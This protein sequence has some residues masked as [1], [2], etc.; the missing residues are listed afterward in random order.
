MPAKAVNG[1][2]AYASD[3]WRIRYLYIDMYFQSPGVTSKDVFS[4]YYHCIDLILYYHLT[5]SYL[6]QIPLPK[7]ILA[8]N[9]PPNNV[10]QLI[11]DYYNAIIYALNKASSISVPKIKHNALKAFWNEECQS[12]NWHKIWSDCGKLQ[13]GIVNDIR[14]YVL[15][16]NRPTSLPFR[17]LLLNLNKSTPMNCMIIGCL[18][19][20]QLLEVLEFKI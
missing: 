4:L 5:G 14:L 12:I 10:N 11:D 2:T 9:N 1:T 18:R 15:N 17:K 7:D 3:T 19:I 6:Q 20:H 16:L 13:T 8:F